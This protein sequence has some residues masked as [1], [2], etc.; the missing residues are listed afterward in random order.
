MVS[1]WNSFWHHSPTARK[2]GD[3][4]TDGSANTS[5]CC[6]LARCER[7]V[8][9]AMR[10]RCS[11]RPAPP[12]PIF[13]AFSAYEAPYRHRLY[14]KFLNTLISYSELYHQVLMH[15]FQRSCEMSEN[16]RVGFSPCYLL[17]NNKLRCLSNRVQ[18][19]LYI[20]CSKQSLS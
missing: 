19:C 7:K 14:N 8:L 15:I 18:F 13:H 6:W 3:G 1:F 16:Y 20:L 11:P 9:R 5:H 10:R 4:P 17:L 12:I 2:K